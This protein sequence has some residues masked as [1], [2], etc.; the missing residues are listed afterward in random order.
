MS[1]QLSAKE[2]DKRIAKFE[3]LQQ[4][5]ELKKDARELERE[6]AQLFQ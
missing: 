5:E 3:R 2:L 6:L 1:K 4:K